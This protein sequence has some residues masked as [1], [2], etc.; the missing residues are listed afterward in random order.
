MLL[1]VLRHA[2]ALPAAQGQADF[3][4]TLSPHGHAQTERVH[5][6]LMQQPAVSRIICSPATRTTQTA[7]R[8]LPDAPI[9]FDER[10]YEA[11]SGTLMQVV[12]EHTDT[13]HLLLVGHNPGLSDLCMHLAPHG[14]LTGMSTA[15]VIRLALPEGGLVEPSG[16]SFINRFDP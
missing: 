6:W 9:G 16:M 4:R 12:A 3:E 7:E 13:E 8:C 2:E 14:V 10:I 15:T 11:T 1:T 5:A